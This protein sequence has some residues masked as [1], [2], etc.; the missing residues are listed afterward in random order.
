M[1]N[2]YE[3]VVI[4]LAAGRRIYWRLVDLLR[5]VEVGLRADACSTTGKVE[6]SES[7]GSD[8]RMSPH[9]LASEICPAETG[10]EVDTVCFASFDF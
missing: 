4:L 8:S 9:L 3:V 5:L 2:T 7:I 1:P 6:D 10:T